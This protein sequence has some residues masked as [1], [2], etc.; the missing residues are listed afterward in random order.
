MALPQPVEL[1]FWR[2]SKQWDTNGGG[3]LWEAKKTTL[4]WGGKILSLDSG[5]APQARNSPN[6]RFWVRRP[7]P[8]VGKMATLSN[9]SIVAV[10]ELCNMDV[11]ATRSLAENKKPK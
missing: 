10:D 3:K 6:F 2:L 4:T 7:N 8:R 1:I 9:R 5:V 11:F